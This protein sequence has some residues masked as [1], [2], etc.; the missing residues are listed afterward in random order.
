MAHHRS[1]IMLV[2]GGWGESEIVPPLDSEPHPTSSRAEW[3]GNELSP[4][5]PR[6]QPNTP[7]GKMNPG[8]MLVAAVPQWTDRRVA[9]ISSIV[10]TEMSTIDHLKCLCGR[11]VLPL[12]P[13]K[14]FVFGC[15]LFKLE[16]RCTLHL[17]G[18][19]SL[20]LQSPFAQSTG[21]DDRVHLVVGLG[22]M[23]QYYTVAIKDN[24]LAHCTQ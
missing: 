12:P 24:S 13:I 18:I 10:Y 2:A 20:K 23:Y 17:L 1:I 3:I 21:G 14:I 7:T 16:H 4:L 11:A 22:G 5:W 15:W 9:L 6:A 8:V 19:C